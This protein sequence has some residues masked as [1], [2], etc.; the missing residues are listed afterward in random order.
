MA[1]TTHDYFTSNNGWHA[2][3]RADFNVLTEGRAR[4]K[5][6]SAT[7]RPVPWGQ[8]NIIHQGGA[9][10]EKLVCTLYLPSLAQLHNLLDCVG[11]HGTLVWE[12]GTRGALL[13]SANAQEWFSGHQ[14][15]VQAEF[16]LT[17]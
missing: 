4:S 11:D 17:E 7:A 1:L 10:V 14:Q 6:A 13:Y 8:V 15:T 12:E 2:G 3:T 5:Q 16:W 9:E